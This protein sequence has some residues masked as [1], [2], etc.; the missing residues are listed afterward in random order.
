[1][2]CAHEMWI[3]VFMCD[4]CMHVC[5]VCLCGMCARVVFV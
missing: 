5:V 4:V 1:M 2:C 3:Y